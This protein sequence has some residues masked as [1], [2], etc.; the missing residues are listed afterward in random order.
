MHPEEPHN[1]WEHET[2][3][4]KE[5]IECVKELKKKR[6]I[7][8]ALSIELSEEELIAKLDEDGDNKISLDEMRNFEKRA[9]RPNE[10]FTIAI[11][12]IGYVLNGKT[13]PDD[14]QVLEEVGLINLSD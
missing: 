14:L 7:F 9:N 8:K 13:D 1:D 6:N 5:A 12:W 11:Y 4:K 3:N 10:T 2:L